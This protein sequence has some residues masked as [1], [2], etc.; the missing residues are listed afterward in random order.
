MRPNR[1]FRIEWWKIVASKMRHISFWV[2]RNP[3]QRIFVLKFFISDPFGPLFLSNISSRSICDTFTQNFWCTFSFLRTMRFWIT[4]Q[5]PFFGG[6]QFAQLK[7]IR[8]SNRHRQHIIFRR[9]HRNW[10]PRFHAIFASQQIRSSWNFLFFTT[11]KYILRFRSPYIRI[12]HEW[13]LVISIDF[14]LFRHSCSRK[15][16]IDVFTR[17]QY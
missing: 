4:L 13:F 14:S 16:N 1:G 6:A 2:W 9:A 11:C 12:R 15:L 10:L 5:L 3:Q 17:T 8:V 7:I